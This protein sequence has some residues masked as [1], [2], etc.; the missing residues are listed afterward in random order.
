M[1]NDITEA[2]AV[3]GV[4]LFPMNT[5]KPKHIKLNLEDDPG[6]A[7]Y[8]LRFVHPINVNEDPQY[9]RLRYFCKVTEWFFRDDEE[10]GPIYPE[11]FDLVGIRHASRFTREGAYTRA[12][13]GA[14]LAWSE[15][16]EGY[17]SESELYSI[18]PCDLFPENFQVV[19]VPQFDPKQKTLL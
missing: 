1:N 17:G 14:L 7:C 6:P 16:V 5:L 13:D 9:I 11:C 19:Y 10:Q 12:N 4:S 2:L 8:V 3:L 15:L 18:A